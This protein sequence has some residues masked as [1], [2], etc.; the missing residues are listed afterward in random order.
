MSLRECSV[1]GT[2]KNASLLD[3]TAAMHNSSVRSSKGTCTMAIPSKITAAIAKGAYIISSSL[4]A[5][6]GL[7]VPS[8]Y[9]MYLWHSLK[10]SCCQ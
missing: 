5:T 4:L 2:M 9:A 1:N 10:K 3:R 6:S 7:R 8:R